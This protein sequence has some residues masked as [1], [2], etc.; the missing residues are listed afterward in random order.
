MPITTADLKKFDIIRKLPEEVIENLARSAIETVVATSR[1]IVDVGDSLSHGFAVKTGIVGLY[2]LRDNGDLIPTDVYGPGRVFGLSVFGEQVPRSQFRAIT[3]MP[4]TLIQVDDSKIRSALNSNA[5][6][7]IAIQEELLASARR[8]LSHAF[9]LLTSEQTSFP[10][11]ESCP[12][13]RPTRFL[14]HVNTA[15]GEV[16]GMCQRGFSCSHAE[17]AGCP[18]A[19]LPAQQ[20]QPIYSLK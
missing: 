11:E 16:R 4:T 5:N 12:S 19:E 8:R 9:R 14:V 2:L 13:G 18:M 6:T 10:S 3:L 7:V 20:L 1:T 15:S 17:G